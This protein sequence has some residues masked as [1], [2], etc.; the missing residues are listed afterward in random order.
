[1]TFIAIIGID[2]AG[3]S[4]IA[5]HLA[6]EMYAMLTSEPWRTP[7]G[8]R[9]R[10]GI[11]S[12]DDALCDRA[13]HVAH[14]IRPA[15]RQGMTVICDR[16]D[17]CMWAYQASSDIEAVEGC[18]RSMRQWPQPDLWVYVDTPLSVCY[19]RLDARGETYDR[20]RLATAARRY[21]MMGLAPMVVVSGTGGWL[22]AVRSIMAALEESDEG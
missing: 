13:A 7:W 6:D 15:L 21:R 3:K 16:Y 18:A 19:D 17:P 5:S 14:V 20:E 10:Q 22:D 9:V 8:D 12:M 2:G 4:T 1:M 11:G